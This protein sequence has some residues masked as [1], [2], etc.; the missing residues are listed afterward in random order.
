MQREHVKS[1]VDGPQSQ[2]AIAVILAVGIS[3]EPA[4]DLGRA[5]IAMLHEQRSAGGMFFRRQL[6]RIRPQSRQNFKGKAV[7]DEV[8]A[9]AERLTL[10]GSKRRAIRRLNPETEHAL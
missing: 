7:G 6:D 5:C 10:A 2:R 1:P 3:G 4:R 8:I 9:L